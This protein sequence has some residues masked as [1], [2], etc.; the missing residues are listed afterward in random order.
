MIVHI[1]QRTQHD[2]AICAVAMVMGPPYTYER[3]LEDSHKYPKGST[4]GKFPSWWE[5]YL[6]DEGFEPVY[7]HFNGLYQLSDYGGS[8]VGLLGMDISACKESAY[9][10]DKHLLIDS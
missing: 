10:R 3:V 8:I 4:D 6:R 1:P 5:S 9:L 2:C 7:C